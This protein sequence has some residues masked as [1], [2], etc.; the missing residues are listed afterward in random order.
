VSRFPDLRSGYILCES[1]EFEMA[2]R[3]QKEIAQAWGLVRWLGTQSARP[4]LWVHRL[5]V[6]C[7]TAEAA[8]Q[9]AECGQ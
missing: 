9:V 8:L 5:R 1:L 4:E 6:A 7:K 2:D 3:Y